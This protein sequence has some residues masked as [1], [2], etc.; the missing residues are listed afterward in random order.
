MESI[1][2]PTLYITDPEDFDIYFSKVYDDIYDDIYYTVEI[3]Q[4]Y[5]R[6][7]LRFIQTMPRG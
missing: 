6:G 2:Y 5:M 7:F 3:F 1:L 4:S